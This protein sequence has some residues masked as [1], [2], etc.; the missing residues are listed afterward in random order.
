MVYI[1]DFGLSKKFREPKTGMHIPQSSKLSLTGTA[2]YA[3]INAHLGFQQSRR[4]DLEAIMY[5]LIYL[6]KGELPWQGLKAKNKH[7]KNSQIMECKMA[8]P[9]LLLCKGLP[10][11]I[12][13]VMLYVKGLEFEEKPNYE[14]IRGKFKNILTRIH[15]N[16]KEELLTDWQLLRKIKRE[17]K[18]EKERAEKAAQELKV[19]SEQIAEEKTKQP[20]APNGGADG[21]Q[22][23]V[24]APA[25]SV[26][27]VSSH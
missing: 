1:I 15:P 6:V 3:S 14:M 26:M 4:D 8:T 11:E 13:D 2:R 12:Y 22:V 20:G 27:R 9:E 17:E 23:N 7:E 19:S 5:M 21:G 24:E 16:K 25:A 10:N 18:K